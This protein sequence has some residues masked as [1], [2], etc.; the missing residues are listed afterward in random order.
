MDYE[1]IPNCVELSENWQPVTSNHAYRKRQAV[2]TTAACLLACGFFS[3][4]YCLWD[5]LLDSDPGFWK[6]MRFWALG[7]VIFPLC[8][9]PILRGIAYSFSYASPKGLY[10]ILA[11]YL[12]AA[13]TCCLYAFALPFTDSMVWKVFIAIPGFILIPA[14]IADGILNMTEYF[15]VEWHRDDQ[16]KRERGR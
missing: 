15:C 3:G 10:A 8:Y 16:R 5:Y 14:L 4:T 11:A 6:V 12:I 2:L 7:I 9:W 1:D 13:S